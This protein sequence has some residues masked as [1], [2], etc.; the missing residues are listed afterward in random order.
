MKFKNR[1]GNSWFSYLDVIKL[2]LALIFCFDI[3]LL[4]KIR[5]INLKS[6]DQI[7][8]V[9]PVLISSSSIIVSIL[10]GYFLNKYSEVRSITKNLKS[11]FIKLQ[12]QLY[13]YLQAFD[14]IAG[15]LVNR[16]NIDAQYPKPYYTLRADP[17][18]WE[19]DKLKPSATIFV[20]DLY[21]SS[22]QYYYYRDYETDRKLISGTMLFSI[23]E[24]LSNL[25]ST[26][27]RRKHYKYILRE[28]GFDEN[29]E[30][31]NVIIANPAGGF[32]NIADRL[33]PNPKVR[34]DS[35]SFWE[36]Q[37]NNSLEIV[38]KMIANQGFRHPLFVTYFRSIFIFLGL[39]LFFGTLL[40]IFLLSFS[41]P[42]IIDYFLS[43][44]SVIG[45]IPSL[46]AILLKLFSE[47]I[48]ET[49]EFSQ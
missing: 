44:V 7:R 39:V 1:K 49:K 31:A 34:W 15:D 46:I 10:V 18:F 25:S 35:L 19:N 29:A 32:K 2:L 21:E 33:D 41:L 37:I 3:Y 12:T 40:P 26:L 16:F 43:Y 17:K 8:S 11:R 4:L 47:V 24:H 22:R 48:K 9:F 6:Y 38:E 45:F 5:V 36:D 23:T 28:L 20:R 13:P 30:L 42:L 14:W 27:G